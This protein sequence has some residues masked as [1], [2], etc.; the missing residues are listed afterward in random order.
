MDAIRSSDRDMDSK[1]TLTASVS[2]LDVPTPTYGSLD[3]TASPPPGERRRQPYRS[4]SSHFKN[5]PQRN[6][7]GRYDNNIEDER[8]RWKGKDREGSGGILPPMV[9]DVPFMGPSLPGIG[10]ASPLDGGQSTL[11]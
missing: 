10:I 1:S 4:R 6:N 2:A 5:L 7:S 3:G 11:R 9:A 8:D